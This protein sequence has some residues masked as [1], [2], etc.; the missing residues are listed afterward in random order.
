MTRDV[1][2]DPN[3]L[4]AFRRLKR[5]ADQMDALTPKQRAAAVP[6]I[7]KQV[8]LLTKTVMDVA[9]EKATVR[10]LKMAIRYV[11]SKTVR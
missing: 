6:L 2:E 4:Q 10:F 7:S 9:G 3:V 5:A 1:H 8:E 11:D